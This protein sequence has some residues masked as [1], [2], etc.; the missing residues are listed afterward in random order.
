MINIIYCDN[1]GRE[2]Y[3]KIIVFI[4][5]RLQ[6]IIF[7][8]DKNTLPL[9]KAITEIKNNF[10]TSIDAEKLQEKTGYSYHHFRH[11]F[12]KHFGMTINHYVTNIKIHYAMHLLRTT[13]MPVKEISYT[14]GFSS[15]TNLNATI[16]KFYCF[17]PSDYRN[18]D[19][20]M[21]EVFN[22]INDMT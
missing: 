2:N 16:K 9:Q 15:V 12:K 18:A 21:L 11:L 7:T 13:D 14:C 20:S 4:L 19:E 22:A 10:P 8:D 1:I 6:S 5:L 3:Q 17:T